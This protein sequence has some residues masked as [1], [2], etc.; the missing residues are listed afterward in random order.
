MWKIKVICPK[1]RAVNTMEDFAYVHHVMH[2]RCTK[3]DHIQP[4][5][6]VR[7]LKIDKHEK[8][9]TNNVRYKGYEINTKNMVRKNGKRRQSR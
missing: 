7:C 4:M 6:L 1:C 3:C 5:S 2:E 9:M 8:K